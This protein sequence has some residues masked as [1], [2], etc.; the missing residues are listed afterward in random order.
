[1][2]GGRHFEKKALNRHIY[3]CDRYTDLDEIWRDD[4]CWTLAADQPFKFR[5]FENP[6]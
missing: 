5:I 3:V 2:A 1:M 4:A 6:R